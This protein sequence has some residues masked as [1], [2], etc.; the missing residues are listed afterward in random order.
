[1]GL[2]T[3]IAFTAVRFQA[4][5]ASFFLNALFFSHFVEGFDVRESFPKALSNGFDFGSHSDVVLFESPLPSIAHHSAAM[6]VTKFVWWNSHHRPYGV[7]LPLIC[8][9]CHAIRPWRE[10]TLL[11]GGWATECENPTCGLQSDGLREHPVAKLSGMKPDNIV[12]VTPVK[13]RPSG[14]FSVDITPEFL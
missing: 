14:W 3:A 6:S 13:K 4:V 11:S 1:M 2:R 7:T 5:L 12:F 10:F 9:V 8:P